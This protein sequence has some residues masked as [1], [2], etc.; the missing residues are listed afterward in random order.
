MFETNRHTH[1]II[2]L[3]LLI[4]S[5]IVVLNLGK[6][7]VSVCCTRSYSYILG[8]C[9]AYLINKFKTPREYSKLHI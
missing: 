2:K 7:T 8:F 9:D 4:P 5:S 3:T 1:H 6:G